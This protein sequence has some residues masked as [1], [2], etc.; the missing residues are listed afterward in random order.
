MLEMLTVVGYS[1]LNGVQTDIAT[2]QKTLV[3]PP[4]FFCVVVAFFNSS[5][6]LSLPLPEPRDMPIKEE[7]CRN[8][9]RGSCQYGERCKFLHSTQ[10]QPKSNVFGVG[11]HSGS[12]QQQN[13]NPYGFGVQNNSQSKGATD[14]GS[15]PSQFK[16]FENKWTRFSPLPTT[17]APSSRKSENKS[18]ATNHKCTDP[19]SC[20]LVIVEDESER[21]LWKLTCYSHSRNTP[22]IIGDI[23]YEEL[24]AAAYDDAKRGLSLQ[25]IVERER[26]LL[27]SKLIEFDNLCKPHAVPPNL[28]L[29]NQNAFTG[30]SPTVYSQTSQN[31]APPSV[32]SF[33]QLGPSHNMAPPASLYNAFGQQNSFAISSQP[34]SAFGINDLP[35]ESAGL[36]G[37]QLPSQAQGSSFSS[38][39]SGFS[40][41][42]V[43]RGSNPF[44]PAVAS[45]QILRTTNNQSP[46]LFTGLDFASNPNAQ[47]TMGVDLVPNVQKDNF[48]GDASI[49]LKNKWNPGEVPEEAPPEAFVNGIS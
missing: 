42:N 16:P 24:R 48:S 41:S 35:S 11:T 27:K 44:S 4:F 43:V 3:G 19:E 12:W 46:I 37:S 38:T 2:P 39:I 1:F 40:N 8:F 5:A 47:A 32:S 17:G 31:S 13:P 18:Q 7:L 21:P 28:I 9:Q 10:Q 30:T 45:A 15:K 34:S 36:F 14:F 22:D 49:W 6:V 26:N 25:S 29:P 23:S 33:S 20:R